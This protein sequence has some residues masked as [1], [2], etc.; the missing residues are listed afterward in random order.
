MTVKFTMLVKIIFSIESLSTGFAQKDNSL[1][2]TFLVP[3]K[4][5]EVC[6]ALVT[7]LTNMT[8]WIRFGC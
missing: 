2:Y 8:I 3:Y 5:V 6:E 4:V 1:M 7:N